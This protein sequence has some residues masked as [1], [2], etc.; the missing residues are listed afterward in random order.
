MLGVWK[1]EKRWHFEENFVAE[2]A[3]L[4]KSIKSKACIPNHQKIHAQYQNETI[5]VFLCGK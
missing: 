1:N 3:S 2:I 4:Q 5:V